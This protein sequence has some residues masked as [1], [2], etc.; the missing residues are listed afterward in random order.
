MWSVRGILTAAV[1]LPG[2][3]VMGVLFAGVRAGGRGFTGAVV[4][5]VV[6]AD[7]LVALLW[8]AVSLVARL[9][10]ATLGKALALKLAS[11][12]ARSPRPTDPERVVS[13]SKV[14]FTRTA[15]PPRARP[16]NV[17]SASAEASA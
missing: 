14:Y 12:S 1:L 8:V 4:T 5:L 10:A 17:V 13:P 3:L 2:W 15:L 11:T 9:S 7:E 16:S 6:G